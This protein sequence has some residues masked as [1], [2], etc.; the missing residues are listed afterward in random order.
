MLTKEKIG[1]VVEKFGKNARN[2]GD[3][4]VQIALLTER[5]N[6]LQPHFAVAKKDHASRRGLLKMVGRRRSLLNHLRDNEPKRY[7]EL[8]S[9]LNLRK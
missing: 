8:L 4:G 5:I 6:G 2:T 9:Q 7:L 3:M 1:S